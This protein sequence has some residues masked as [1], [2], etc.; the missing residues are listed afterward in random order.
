MIITTLGT[1]ES[2]AQGDVIIALGVHALDAPANAFIDP[3]IISNQEAV[4]H[5]NRDSMA[6]L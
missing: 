5:G 3:A 6:A 4:E 2:K 1:E